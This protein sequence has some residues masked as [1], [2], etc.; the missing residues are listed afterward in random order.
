MIARVSTRQ[1]RIAQA[2]GVICLDQAAKTSLTQK[3]QARAQA[4]RSQTER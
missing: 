4:I 2:L 1:S 3:L